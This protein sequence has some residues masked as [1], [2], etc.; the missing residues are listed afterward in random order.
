MREMKSALTALARATGAA[1]GWKRHVRQL[2]C[3]SIPRDG[4]CQPPKRVT[5]TSGTHCRRGQRRHEGD[6]LRPWLCASRGTAWLPESTVAAT[7]RKGLVAVGGDKWALPLSMVAFRDRANSQRSLNLFWS[8][9]CR[10]SAERAGSGHERSV[11]SSSAKLSVRP[12]VKPS[13]KVPLRLPRSG[14]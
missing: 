1:I 4:I 3:R 11:L 12:S 13:A 14:G 2:V 10:Y 8:E 6:L 5:P 9:P 7:G